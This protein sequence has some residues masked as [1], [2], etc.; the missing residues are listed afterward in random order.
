MS[1][2]NQLTLLRIVLTPVVAWMLFR[3]TYSW[4]MAAFAVYFIAS[5][6]DWY[7]GYVARK[8][9]IVT[10]WG[11]FLDPL[12]DK[13]LVLSTMACFSLLGYFPMWM[14][15]VVLVRDIGITILRTYALIKGRQVV[16]SLLAKA[17]T[18]FQMS[19]IYLIFFLHLL[20]DHQNSSL[21]NKILLWCQS[22][23]LVIGLMVLVVFLTIVSGIT[24]FIV[25][26]RHVRS[27]SVE[28]FRI[29]IP[30]N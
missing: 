26:R 18:F 27:M 21:L 6:T 13:V 9:G 11:K 14:V 7:D 16:T 8:W 19:V 22:I 5:L 23:N 4:K 12:A 2:P 28:L 3:E 1:L 30:S 15:V 17:K 10:K 24:Y 25:N 29:F 20:A